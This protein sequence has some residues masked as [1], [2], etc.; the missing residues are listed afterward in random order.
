[1]KKGTIYEGIVKELK[2]PNQGVVEINDGKAVV[3]NTIP[4]QK[5][6]FAVTKV[7][8]EKAEGRLLEILEPSPLETVR[9]ICPHFGVCGGCTYQSLPYETQLEIKKNQVKALLDGVIETPY[10][11]EGIKGSPLATEYRNKMEFSF[12]DEVKDGP[13]ALG[14]HKR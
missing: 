1:M 7:R 5:I 9:D 6:R 14:M 4:G 8:K 11:F 3:K 12:G 10:V 2:F 13:L